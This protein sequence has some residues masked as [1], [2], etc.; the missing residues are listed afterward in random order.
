MGG[1]D[2]FLER[3]QGLLHQRHLIAILG[4]NVLDRAPAGFADKGTVHQDDVFYVFG[5]RC[6]ADARH[7]TDGRK[8]DDLDGLTEGQFHGVFLS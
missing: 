8:G 1:G 7:Q 5:L 4:K 6:G 3:S 2:V